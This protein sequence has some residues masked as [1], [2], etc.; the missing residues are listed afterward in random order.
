[1]CYNSAANPK[2]QEVFAPNHV[3]AKSLYDAGLN[4][5]PVVPLHLS[6]GQRKPPIEW[7]RWKDEVYP[8]YPSPYSGLT[9]LSRWWQR[10][11]PYGIFIICGFTSG[12]LEVLDFDLEADTHFRKTWRLFGGF[13]I[14]KTPKGFHVIWRWPNQQK[15]AGEVLA[16][17]E[18]G[19]VLLETRGHGHLVQTVGSPPY[20][21]P[22]G[23]TY[24]LL[25][26]SLLAIPEIAEDRRAEIISVARG[27]DRS[28]L[29]PPLAAALDGV[30]KGRVLLPLPIDAGPKIPEHKI[31]TIGVGHNVSAGHKVLAAGLDEPKIGQDDTS[32]ASSRSGAAGSSSGVPFAGQSEECLSR[33]GGSNPLPSGSNP[34]Q[35]ALCG[36]SALPEPRLP[37]GFEILDGETPADAW[38]RQASWADMLEPL[39]FDHVGFSNGWELWR[40]PG[41]LSDTNHISCG[42]HI[43]VCHSTA[44]LPLVAGERYSKFALLALL[45]FSADRREAARWLRRSAK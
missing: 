26:G 10:S 11:N 8:W 21:H 45:C 31:T 5:L 6:R 42:D 12:N 23:K 28:H 20:C 7:T 39:G 30:G 22:S 3:W 38:T 15:R 29:Q 24:R 17:T 19:K 4:I 36:S 32:P 35:D 40:K 43:M 37:D 33:P 41:S 18:T 1:M 34:L 27:F 9:P 25:A 16:R 44:C 14:I 2:A 13:P